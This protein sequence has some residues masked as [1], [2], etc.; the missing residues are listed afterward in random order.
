M[1]VAN[2]LQCWLTI[3]PKASLCSH[4]LLA[5]PLGVARCSP[6]CPPSLPS[7]PNRHRFRGWARWGLPQE[8]KWL[9]SSLLRDD[10][11]HFWRLIVP[12]WVRPTH[13]CMMRKALAE[14]MATKIEDALR[15]LCNNFIT[16]SFGST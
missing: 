10:E 7:P 13:V 8:P 16:S 2:C 6:R 9:L 3:T 1:S 14:I 5:K 4:E 11:S 15:K 12:T